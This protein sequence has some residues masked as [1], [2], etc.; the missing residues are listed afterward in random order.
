MSSTINEK[1]MSTID[2]TKHFIA[3]NIFVPDKNSYNMCYGLRSFGSE[4]IIS[5]NN[6]I[7]KFIWLE[8]NTNEAIYI[9]KEG[10]MHAFNTFT[11]FNENIIKMKKV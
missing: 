10:D 8:T 7:W 11:I 9:N 5:Y 3:N 6:D 2:E 4:S 1:N